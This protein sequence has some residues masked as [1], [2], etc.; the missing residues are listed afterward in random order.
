M[1]E[2][3][4]AHA[5]RRSR[6]SWSIRIGND[7]RSVLHGIRV[8]A[9][10]LALV[11]TMRLAVAGLAV[12]A[13]A[14]CVNLPDKPAYAKADQAA[15]RHYD[16]DWFDAARIGRI[17]ILRALLDAGY[18]IDATDGHGYTAVILAGYDNQPAALE[19]L[20]SAGANPCLGDRHGNTALM[21]VLFKGESAIARRLI[22]TQCPIDQMNNAGETAL[23]FATLFSRTD[24]VPI[25]VKHG[26]DPNHVDGRGESLL[27][28]ARAQ[29]DTQAADALRKVGATR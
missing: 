22:D 2:R 4:A 16:D 23:D 26:A 18:P 9:K 14:G 11:R 10:A 13:I 6:F 21:G 27:Q 25:L 19:F 17:D 5:A 1:C 29:G 7:M 3:R 24:I 28:L 20:L 15:L 12:A 8:S